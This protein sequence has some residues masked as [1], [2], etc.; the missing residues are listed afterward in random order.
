MAGERSPEKLLPPT[1]PGVEEA[2]KVEKLGEV[3]VVI[4]AFN[5][6][7]FL[8][9]VLESVFRQ[10]HPPLEI[11]VVD[12][13]STDGTPE[14][15][16]RFQ[17]RVH[18]LRQ[19]NG[20]P[21]S[22]R[23]RGILQ[24]RGEWIAFL[25]ADDLWLPHRIEHQLAVAESTQAD[26]V[27]SDL[28]EEFSTR[29]FPSYL[30]GHRQK[31][32]LTAAVRNGI[33]PNPFQHLIRIGNFI[34]PSA[35]LIRRDCLLDVGLFDENLRGPEDFDLWLRLSLKSRVAFTPEPLVIRRVYDRNLTEDD[36]N[37]VAESLKM[38]EKIKKFEILRGQ[39][40]WRRVIRKKEARLY[41]SRGYYFFERNQPAAA[42][43]SWA[44]G[45]RVSFSARMAA[46]WT[47]TLLPERWVIGL[48]SAVRRIKRWRSGQRRCLDSTE[49]NW[50]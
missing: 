48:R 23:N 39:R 38:W 28:V 27:F 25:D 10:T 4:P 47:V 17:G 42:R 33:L 1:L 32:P 16:Q 2:V 3:S 26:L 5:A 30:E 20:G 7:E 41:W 12:D 9:Q 19:D 44:T 36:E 40:Q 34:L 8:P 18:Y 46:Y 15:M 24:A 49:K 35:V 45:L 43:A 13:G 21:A 22:A 37:M 6:A 50:P 14:T 31:A 11:I 29:T